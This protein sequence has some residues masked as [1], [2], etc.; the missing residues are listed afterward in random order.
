[1]A[2]ISFNL[3][4]TFYN[5]YIKSVSTQIHLP[6]PP[7]APKLQRAKVFIG[8]L[9]MHTEYLN[10]HLD[11]ADIFAEGMQHSNMTHAS[12]EMCYVYSVGHQTYSPNLVYLCS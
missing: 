4:F 7:I 6:T 11:R 5:F 9:L 8:V 10:Q 1:M 12:G 2:L 3:N